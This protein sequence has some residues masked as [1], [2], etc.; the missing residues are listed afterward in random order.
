M[1]RNHP[2]TAGPDTADPGRRSLLLRGGVQTFFDEGPH[3]AS[4][5]RAQATEARPAPAPKAPAAKA[6]PVAKAKG[7]MDYVAEAMGAG[8]TKSQA[9]RAVAIAHPDLHREYIDEHNAQARADVQRDR[10]KSA[11]VRAAL[12]R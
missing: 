7:F 1:G 10:E 5:A 3:P 11:R 8:K 6:A 9:V 2:A 12:R 4:T